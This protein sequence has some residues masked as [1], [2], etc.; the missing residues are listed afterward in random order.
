MIKIIKRSL[1]K[2]SNGCSCAMNK[3]E[4]W[5]SKVTRFLNWNTLTT[6]TSLELIPSIFQDVTELH[7][8]ATKLSGFV[9]TIENS[10]VMRIRSWLMSRQGGSVYHGKVTRNV[11]AEMSET[12]Y[13]SLSNPSGFWRWQYS[14]VQSRY[15]LMIQCFCGWCT[16]DHNNTVVVQKNEFLT[17]LQDTHMLINYCTSHFEVLSLIF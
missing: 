12:Q 1:D 7:W 4:L 8:K 2:R 9:R 17:L 10:R 5:S 6:C 3:I 13:W 11:S 14:W 15:F 16:S